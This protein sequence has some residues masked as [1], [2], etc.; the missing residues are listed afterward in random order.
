MNPLIK[1]RLPKAPEPTLPQ[2][3]SSYTTQAGNVVMFKP[4]PALNDYT[5]ERRERARESRNKGTREKWDR[6]IKMASDNWSDKEIAEALGYSE[7]YV[8]D[9]LK[10]LRRSGVQ[11]PER[12]RGRKHG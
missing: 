11:I 2:K 9:R 1:R 10:Q 7:K 8:H 12:K 3:T 4:G 5:E 6:M